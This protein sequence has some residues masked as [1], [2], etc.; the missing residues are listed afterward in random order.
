MDQ[1]TYNTVYNALWR[2]GMSHEYADQEAQRICAL[3]APCGTPAPIPL[4]HSAEALGDLAA[5]CVRSAGH[6]GDHR[7]ALGVSW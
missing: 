4:D 2:R 5:P 1:A 7:N 3:L 6:A